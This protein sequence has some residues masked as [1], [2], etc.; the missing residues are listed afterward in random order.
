[1]L[2][3]C[4]ELEILAINMSRFCAMVHGIFQVFCKQ[5]NALEIE[6]FCIIED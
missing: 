5:K 6:V 2:L 1:M 3:G 4:M